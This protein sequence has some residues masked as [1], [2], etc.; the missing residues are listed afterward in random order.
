MPRFEDLTGKYFGFLY[1]LRRAP[2]KN[3]QTRYMCLCVR[4]GNLV[5]V[6]GASLRK[7]RTKSCGCWHREVAAET[8]RSCRVH[9]QTHSP[10]YFAWHRAKRRVTIPN[11][12]D[13][14]LYGGRGIRMCDRW[15]HGEEGKTGS[16]CFVADM[17]PRPSP[18]HSLDRI[19]V[20][21]HYEPG[22]CRW[23]TSREQSNNRRSNIRVTIHGRTQTT[24]EWAR[25]AGISPSAIKD[26]VKS[27][28]TPEQLLL[29]AEPGKALAYRGADAKPKAEA[30]E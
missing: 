20:N 6:I 7:G 23:A 29:P 5:D 1:V 21:G 9:A 19:D 8:G 13:W 25:A 15:I 14:H 26:R 18:M 24:A 3:N 2:N 16:Q 28:W 27:G 11:S 12:P 30:A 22:N 4:D 10:E 17:G